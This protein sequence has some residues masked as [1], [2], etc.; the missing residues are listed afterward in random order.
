MRIFLDFGY[1]F[2]IMKLSSPI[3]F[4]GLFKLPIWLGIF[5][6]VIGNHIVSN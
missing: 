5:G 2:D 4:C 3:I 1:K 6:G